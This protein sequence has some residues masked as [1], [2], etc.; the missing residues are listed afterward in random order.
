MLFLKADEYIQK[1]I[2]DKHIPY[3]DVLVKKNHKTIYRYMGGFNYQPTGKEV[4]YFYSLTKPLTSVCILKLLQEKKLTLEDCVGDY[5]PEYNE[6]FLFDEQMGKIL[7]KNKIKIKHLLTM[8][9][10]LTYDR[11][12]EPIKRIL[13]EKGEDASTRDLVKAFAQSPLAFEPGTNFLYSLCFDVLGAII[14][15]VTGRTFSEYVSSVIF[16]PLQ[17]ESCGF[18]ENRF[19][20]DIINCYRYN[21]GEYKKDNIFYSM[22]LSK[23]YESG[24]AGLIGTVE[25]YSLFADMLACQGVA[26]NGREIL[27]KEYIQFLKTEQVSKISADIAF[28]CFQNK[29]YG[30]GF[31]VRVRKNSL[32]CGLPKGE[33]GWDGAAGSYVMVDTDNH[34]SVTIGMHIL[35]WP[36]VIE[37]EHLKIVELIYSCLNKQ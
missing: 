26:E 1:L 33:F 35:N 13:K 11:E 6:V 12:T 4:L 30:Y 19:L 2:K 22:K 37:K 14:E 29:D 7:P 23:K 10:G 21:N 3:I 15:V 32:E 36:S 34:I 20:K 8:S 5:L 25:N 9:A 24:G 18:D 17:M 27:S 28:T 31:G 16:N